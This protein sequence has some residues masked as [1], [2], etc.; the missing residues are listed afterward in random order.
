[1]SIVA[2]PRWAGARGEEPS[3]PEVLRVLLKREAQ[4]LREWDAEHENAGM[5]ATEA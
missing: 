5:A 4:A 2:H 3:G 1:M